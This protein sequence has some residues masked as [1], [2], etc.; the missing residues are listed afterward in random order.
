MAEVNTFKMGNT[1]ITVTDT[2]ARNNAA[3]ALQTATDAK[4]AAQTA[5]A[6]ATAANNT[7]NEA[8]TTAEGVAADATQAKADAAEAKTNAANADANATKAAADASAAKT[9][10]DALY[11]AGPFNVKYDSGTKTITFTQITK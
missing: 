4:S 6:T 1:S 3:A 9:N 11:T 7:A 10:V 2:T 8:K 5:S